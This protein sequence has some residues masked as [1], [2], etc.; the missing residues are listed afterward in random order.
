MRPPRPHPPQVALAAAHLHD[1]GLLHRDI[2]SRNVLLAPGGGDGAGGGG[3]GGG[4][5]RCVAKLG[6]FGCARRL[7]PP[8]AG[9]GGGGGGG[10]RRG[11]H[12]EPS[13]I[14][15]TPIYMAPE[16]LAGSRRLCC[17]ADVWALG[18]LAHETL[19]G[20]YPWQVGRAGKGAV[21]ARAGRGLGGGCASA[22]G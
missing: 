8:Q 1:L 11:W 4:G 16:Q 5:A 3:G 14:A 7:V 10:G 19:T 6:D 12:Y 17:G 22:R 9:G 20:R 2:N 13:A 18:V 21:C 15:G